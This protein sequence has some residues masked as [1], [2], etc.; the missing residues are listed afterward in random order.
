MNVIEFLDLKNREKDIVGVFTDHVPSYPRYYSSKHCEF[1]VDTNKMRLKA[2]K[3]DFE[4]GTKK[5][6]VLP[7]S[8][9]GKVEFK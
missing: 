1:Y 8:T 9:I 2:T 4:A 6:W 7:Y 5:T 3:I